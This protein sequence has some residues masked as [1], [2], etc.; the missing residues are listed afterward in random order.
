MREVLLEDRGLKLVSVLESDINP[1]VAEMEERGLADFEEIYHLSP[2]VALHARLEKP[3]MHAVMFGPEVVAMTGLDAGGVMWALF[4]TKMK[5]HRHKF[6]RASPSLVDYYQEIA[7]S[8][9]EMHV[10]KRNG[11]IIQ[12]AIFCG[13]LP[14]NHG[15]SKY[16]VRL[17]RCLP[18][19]SVSE[20]THR[21][22]VH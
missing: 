22:A 7:G 6:L 4:S 2:L 3:N 8:D 11:A 14:E 17:V 21:P 13:F 12:W 9:L 19:K 18:R 1:F 5:E 20:N 10:P 15:G 16:L